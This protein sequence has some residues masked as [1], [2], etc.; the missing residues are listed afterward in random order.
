MIQL[1]VDAGHAFDYLSIL[2]VKADMAPTDSVRQSQH[3]QCGDQIA[4]QISGMKF[5][6]I[7]RSREYKDLYDANLRMFRLVDLAKTDK[8]SASEVDRANYHR[9]L[10][11]MR[12]QKRFFNELL[13]E[14]KVGYEVYEDAPR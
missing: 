4:G 9:Y 13:S 2:K 8:V 14:V 11:K 12:L 1:S 3:L 10:Q 7:L 5:G 6:E